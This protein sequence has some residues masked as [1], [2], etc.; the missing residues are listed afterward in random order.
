MK[1]CIFLLTVLLSGL[2]VQKSYAQATGNN[3]WTGTPTS[4]LGWTTSHNIPFYI[5]ANN[6]MDLT[7]AKNL[8]IRTSTS[9]YQVDSNMVLWHNGITSCIYVG[10]GA[11]NT[12]AVNN[13][14][15]LGNY[16]GNAN[17][18]YDN[19]GIGY[20]ALKYNTYAYYNTAV[21]KEA[22][23]TQS[24]ANG[25]T[26]YPTYNT[27]IGWR[28]LYANQPTNTSN[29][30]YN[31]AVGYSALSANQTGYEN[32]AMGYALPSNTYASQNTAVGYSALF[33]QDFAN[34]NVEYTTQNTAVGTFALYKNNPTGTNNG[35][36]NTAL[37]DATLFT[38]TIGYENTAVG[39]DALFSNI[40][41]FLNSANGVQALNSNITGSY[42]TANGSQALATNTTGSFNSA[43]G[44]QADVTPGA[45]NYSTAVGAYATTAAS[46]QMELGD[47]NEI[48]TLGMSTFAP[49]NSPV[50]TRLEINTAKGAAPFTVLFNTSSPVA[51]SPAQGW[52]GLR[53]DDLTNASLPGSNSGKNG[54]LALNSTGDVIYVTNT[55]IGY[56]PTLTA[57]TGSGGYDMGTN[58]K[59]FYFSGQNS[60]LG[61]TDVAIGTTCTYTPVA[62]LDVLQSSSST[63]GSIGIYVTNTDAAT[64]N[65]PAVI[66]LKS[67]MPTYSVTCNTPERTVAGWLE[68]DGK[69]CF[70][71]V[72]G[73]TIAGYNE[74]YALFIPGPYGGG[75]AI[76]FPFASQP[77]VGSADL[78][79]I[80]SGIE[81]LGQ[82]FPSDTTIKRNVAYF[83]SGIKVIRQL[84]PVSYQ[85]NGLGGFD[86][87]GTYIGVIA[88][89]LKRAGA[90]YALRNEVIV[91]DTTTHDTAN[92]FAIYGEA[93]MY[94]AINAIKEVD[95]VNTVQQNTI[96]SLRTNL[97]NLTISYDSVRSVFLSYISCLNSLCGGL[98]VTA[99]HGNGDGTSNNNTNPALNTQEITLSGSTGAPLLYQNVPN[100]F[101][102]GTKINYYLPE[103]TMGANIVFYDTYGNM[104]KTV[105]LSQTGNGTLN[106]TPD[107]LS[108]GIYSYSLI[109]NGAVIDTKK[110]LLQK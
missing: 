60:N 94:T 34:S 6:L 73:A 54:L 57:M 92:I 110:M 25:G 101:S 9:G 33:T 74:N 30:F 40:N 48:V 80:N 99:P 49:T 75:V 58:A 10:V 96:D 18:T 90:T 86:T 71:I 55:G 46:H 66:G 77:Q 42:N 79:N 20:Q 78:L 37:G 35:Y 2:I 32:T 93:V 11:G 7:T 39:S 102:V 24:Y 38:N 64:S 82:Y 61:L 65:L 53:F 69:G 44:Y 41:G 70:S 5:G 88:Q 56:C 67:F 8:N 52:S 83:N 76:G 105:Q 14:T 13:C 104:I 31:T 12:N 109:V 51:A 36:S 59:D 21:G 50:Y 1:K 81:Y 72:P 89:N 26:P 28:A 17:Y 91:K 3:V 85:Y 15:F 68:A 29:G 19:T 45:I 4:Y 100:P 27:A 47:N 16:A 108:N 63:N 107:N 62:K 23:Y 43:L 98:G 87:G 97:K 106:I 95:S 84:R 103:G 22:L